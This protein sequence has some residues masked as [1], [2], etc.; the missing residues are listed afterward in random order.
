MTGRHQGWTDLACAVSDLGDRV[1]G[2]RR[3][4]HLGQRSQDLPVLAGL[5]GR[6]DHVAS[7]LCAALRVYIGGVLLG[8]G[9]SGQDDV[10]DLG[11]L[12]AVVTLVD[13]ERTCFVQIG[14]GELLLV[15]AEQVQDLRLLLTNGRDARLVANVQRSNLRCPLKQLK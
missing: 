12:V 6:S 4:E 15:G 2:Q 11:A 10:G 3:A 1:V 8:V 9:R 13:H 7:L 5:A 14:L